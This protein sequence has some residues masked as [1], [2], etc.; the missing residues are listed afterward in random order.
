M[1][2]YWV[3]KVYTAHFNFCCIYKYICLLY[4]MYEKGQHPSFQTSFHSG[5]T[6]EYNRIRSFQRSRPLTTCFLR[7]F[8]FPERRSTKGYLVDTIFS[9]LILTLFCL[10]QPNIQLNLITFLPLPAAVTTAGA[11]DAHSW[12]LTADTQWW[13]TELM[14]RLLHPEKVQVLSTTPIWI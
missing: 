5:Q 10:K 2:I 11:Y 4:S 1:S 14:D 6:G 12:E 9:K 8:C 3:F 7:Y 13:N